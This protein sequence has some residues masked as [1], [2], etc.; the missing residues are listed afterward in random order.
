[1]LDLVDMESGCAADEEHEWMII[2]PKE[3]VLIELHRRI[4]ERDQCQLV[5]LTSGLVILE[6]EQA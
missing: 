2:S 1:M 6:Q 4:S 5:R 3:R